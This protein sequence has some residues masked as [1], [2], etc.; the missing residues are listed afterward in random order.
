MPKDRWRK[1]KYQLTLNQFELGV[2]AED[3][4]RRREGEERNEK[5]EREQERDRERMEREEGREPG[6]GREER[7][8][9]CRISSIQTEEGPDEVHFPE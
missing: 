9:Q 2:T 3:I 6:K 5:R 1:I 8:N 4:E 7:G